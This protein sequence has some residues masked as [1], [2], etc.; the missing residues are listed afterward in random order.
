M[1][2]HKCSA[3]QV[4]NDTYAIFSAAVTSWVL[5]APPPRSL[6]LVPATIWLLPRVG[7]YAMYWF[8]YITVQPTVWY[9]C[10]SEW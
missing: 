8:A 4:S 7:A 3:A 9:D 2:V 5:R 10:K 1:T 6:A